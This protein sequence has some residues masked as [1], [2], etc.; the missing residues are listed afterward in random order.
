MAGMRTEYDS[1]GAICLPA[2]ALYGSNTARGMNHSYSER[3]IK[4]EPDF[5]RSFVQC[6]HAAALANCELGIIGKEVA[7]A[8]VQ[9]CNEL[10]AG[11]HSRDLVIDLMESSGGTSTNMNFNEVIAN[12]AQQILGGAIG[13]YD[14]VHPNDHVNRSQSTN[15]VYPSAMKIV[16]HGQLGALAEEMDLLSACLQNK[17]NQF[18]D[19]LRLGRTCMQD[20]QPMYLG[21]TF[22]G[23]AGLTVRLA[24]SVRKTQTVLLALPLGSTAIGTGFGS[25][26]GYKNAVFAHLRRITNT[27]FEPA[28]NPFDAM[29]NLDVFSEV[30]SLLRT[31]AIS[32]AKIASDL[33]VL[34]S[35]PAGGLGELSL[36]AVQPGS[37]IM[38]GKVNP[39]IAMGIVQSGFAV[40]GN[41]AC[42]AQAVQAGQLE[43]N[44]FEPI[45]L[46]RVLDS[47]RLL[48]RA[49]PLFRERCVKGIL[50]DRLRSETL[51]LE[52]SAVATAFI[53]EL[54]YD[55][56]AAMVKSA[57]LNR[58]TFIA[59]VSAA[60]LIAE[61]DARE[62]VRH[63]AMLVPA[64]GQ[65]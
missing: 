3:R 46:S 43:I 56:V 17:S 34:G 41:D 33:I 15:D 44:H 51:V 14:T 28:E 20:A 65:P 54:G 59:Q 21:Q 29:Q 38:P 61:E 42:V 11:Q 39:V 64:A 57:N 52:S 24:E 62:L 25:P 32:L 35:G 48:L 6:K 36:P 60:G 12:R 19:V 40:S 55:A 45:V 13:K 8:I 7:D 4:D 30:S 37:S 23:Y 31:C 10:I 18:E 9:T 22:K 16:A 26:P 49:I 47:T 63:A 50:A 53:P 58:T 27:K 2:D 1:L 5:V